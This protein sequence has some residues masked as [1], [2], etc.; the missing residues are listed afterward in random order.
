M[1]NILCKRLPFQAD[2]E[3]MRLESRLRWEARNG[4]QTQGQMSGLLNC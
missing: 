2:L 1:V 3:S 4:A